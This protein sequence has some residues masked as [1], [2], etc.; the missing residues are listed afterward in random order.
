M[1]RPVVV[2]LSFFS[3]LTGLAYPAVVTGVGAVAFPHQANGSVVTCGGRAVGSSLIAQPFEAAGYFHPR[4]SAV[5]YDAA[6]S[7][8]SNLGPSNPALVEAMTGRAAAFT[9]PSIPADAVTTSASG[10]DPHVSVENAMLQVDRVAAARATPADAVRAMVNRHV[11]PALLG[12]WGEPRVNVL[13]LN[14]ELDGARCD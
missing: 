10:L 5:A 4:P 9:A 1:V 13:R 8:G 2:L 11:E 3:V 12:F 14:L 6:G 7:G